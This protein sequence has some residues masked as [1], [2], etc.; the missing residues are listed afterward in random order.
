[1][2]LDGK[3]A[4]VT[5]GAA[6]I[7]SA[8]V[9]TLIEA[10]AFVV[11]AD[12]DE[13][14]GRALHAALGPRLRFVH[15]D[16]GDDAA[17]DGLV[18]AALEVAGRIDI[19]VNNAVFYG[20]RGAEATRAE[21]LH[22]LD[23]NLV[24]GA[25]LVHKASAHLARTAGAVVNMGSVGGKFGTAG[26]ALYPAAK[27]AILQLTRNQAA[28]LAPQGVRVN[29][30]SPG[31]TWSDA[32]SRMAGGN[33]AYADAIAAPLHPLGRAGDADD[34][35]QVV[36]FLCSDAA[37]FVTGADI[38]VDGGFSMLGPDQGRSARDWFERGA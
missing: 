27:A 12:I 24:S 26:R 18:E 8:I 14:R 3:V 30:V 10:G 25:L 33:R 21:W 32:L 34:V 7:G 35:A 37:R 16:I 9:R 19:V 5:G 38:P 11:A 15:A 31:W 17:L 29:S 1:M 13:A 2:T 36:L 22:A 28:T 4:I 20:D 6:V 23:I